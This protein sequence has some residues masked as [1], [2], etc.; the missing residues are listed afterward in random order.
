MHGRQRHCGK[1]APGAARQEEF[2]KLAARRVTAADHDRLEGEAGQQEALESGRTA[3]CET[4]IGL[5]PGSD[6]AAARMPDRRGAGR[7]REGPAGRTFGCDQSIRLIVVRPEVFRLTPTQRMA[8]LVSRPS[9]IVWLMTSSID[10]SVEIR[11][12]E[13]MG[14]SRLMADDEH[15]G[16]AAVKQ[17]Q[18]HRRIGR[19]KQRSLPFDDID[20]IVVG[21]RCQ[22][23]R[24]A[25]DEVGHDRV[26]RN[27]RTGDHDAG[28]AG[29]PKCR[30]EAP[31]LKPASDR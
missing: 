28:L 27:A 9:A 13:H 26:D 6:R 23:F 11:I 16:L 30:V 8:G 4:S 29:R 3:G 14:S 21:G 7:Q 18:R 1:T 24:R 17:A 20:V 10:G 5:S 15:V 25:G 22:H 12:A 19:M 31:R 2:R